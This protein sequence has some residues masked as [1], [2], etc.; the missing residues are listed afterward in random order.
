MKFVDITA[1]VITPNS[2][3]VL[4]VFKAGIMEIADLFVIN[5]SDLPGVG[6]LR[7]LLKELVSISASEEYKVPIIKVIAT[8]NKGIAE[9]WKSFTDHYT[10]LY[11]TT[12]GRTQREQQW[13]LEVMERSEE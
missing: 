8:E 12:A 1:V 5:K 9:L 6:R 2:G 10:Y 11:E 13:E 7:G 3:D 4:Q